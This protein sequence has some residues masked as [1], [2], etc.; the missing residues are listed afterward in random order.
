MPR[1]SIDVEARL[2][3]FEQGIKSMESTVQRAAG[4]MSSALGAIGVGLS[5][6]GLTAFIKNAIDAADNLNKLSQRVGVT[7]ENLSALQYAGKLADVSTEQLG[8]SLKKLSVNLQEGAAGSAEL[9]AAFQAVGIGA[10]ELGTL[11]PDQA[12]AR[13]ADAFAR[14][15]DGAGKTAIAVRLFGRAGSDLIPLLNGG[16]A[17]LRDAAD[18]ARRFGLI[19][20]SD[21]AKAAEAFNDNLTRIQENA[22]AVGIAIANDAL[23][24]IARFT[25]ELQEG[26]R[27]F[28]NFGSAV[29]QLGTVNPFRSLADNLKEVNREIAQAERELAN[30]KAEGNTRLGGLYDN[31]ELLK[32]RREFLQFQQRALIDTNNPAALDA[33]DLALRQAAVAPKAQLALPGAAG[34]TGEDAL[35]VRMAKGAE[36]IGRMFAQ[37]QLDQLDQLAKMGKQIQADLLEQFEDGQALDERIARDYQTRLASVLG[38]SRLGEQRELAA[39]LDVVNRAFKE[40]RI[41]VEQL[42]SAYAALRERANNIDGLKQVAS[43][44]DRQ[45]QSFRQLE[46]AIRGWGNQFNES[47]VQGLRRGKLEVKTI[48]D[49]ILTDIARLVLFRA[50]TQPLFGAVSNFAGAYFGGANFQQNPN[51]Y[52][53]GGTRAMGGDVEAG[54]LYRVGESGSEWFVPSRDGRIVPG[55]DRAQSGG[56]VTIIVNAPTDPAIIRA[57]AAQGVALSNSQFGRAA[58]IGALS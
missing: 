42:D 22:R 40:N 45:A 49:S 2:A 54:R 14:A 39:D 35:A 1:L 17:G 36:R 46:D 6:A 53:F 13:I 32:K 37:I 58:R 7:V 30:S 50:V 28:G 10:K 33:R 48:V 11:G 55:A 27:I 18:E 56:N 9:R 15:E 16:A 24:S 19:V 51:Y 41:S 12:L 3:R 57:A 20:S 38:G 44:A 26:I 21:A 29:F 25:A 47:L 34:D 43:D 5:A 8:D 23:P 31:V 52:Q 4:A